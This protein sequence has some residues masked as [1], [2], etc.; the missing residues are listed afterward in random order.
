MMDE[1]LCILLHF[2][3]GNNKSTTLVGKSIQTFLKD[4]YHKGKYSLLF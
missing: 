4:I 2:H 1:G 3:D